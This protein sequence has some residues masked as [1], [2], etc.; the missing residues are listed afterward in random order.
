[1]KKFLAAAALLL[2]SCLSFAQTAPAPAEP[3]PLDRCLPIIDCP[4]GYEGLDYFRPRDGKGWHLL[5]F[6]QTYDKDGKLTVRPDGWSCAHG[7]CNID[8]FK[9]TLREL[10]E[11][12]DF[13]AARQ[14]AFDLIAQ[15]FKPLDCAGVDKP[16]CDERAVIVAREK[17]KALEMFAQKREFPP[18]PGPIYVV[19]ANVSCSDPTGATCTRPVYEVVNGVRGTKE[20]GRVLTGTVCDLSWKQPSNS[21]YWAL[22]APGK[23]ALCTLKN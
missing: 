14:K 4:Q 5:W 22:I 20:I 12:D 8:A 16:L 23:A 15:Y 17:P 2:A 18:S 10:R 19:K 3:L 1:M 13:Q 7:V 6:V 21:D 9:D 11:M